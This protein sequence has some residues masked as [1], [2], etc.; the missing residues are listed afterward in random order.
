MDELLAQI[1]THGLPLIMS[2]L[3]L[4]FAVR[5]GNLY[6]SKIKKSTHTD[7]PEE[8]SI[9]SHSILGTMDYILKIGINR[10]F[11]KNQFRQ[12]LFHDLLL[13]RHR[14]IKEHVSRIVDKDVDAMTIPELEKYLFTCF[15]NMI[16][17]IDTQSEQELN[18]SFSTVPDHVN[19]AKKILD[20]FNNYFEHRQNMLFSSMYDLC[21]T[22][23]FA[24]NTQRVSAILYALKSLSL[25]LM[26][27]AE[28]AMS[29]MNGEFEGWTYK[30][31]LNEGD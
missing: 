10:L 19:P 2:A 30:G 9:Q 18:V 23:A 25:L 11:F 1:E 12:L 5:L 3:M 26:L 29:S 7:T 15:T 8:Y 14:V 27:D 6:L 17:D 28:K 24:T 20:S 4:F 31:I 13:I 22:H 21:S 16:I